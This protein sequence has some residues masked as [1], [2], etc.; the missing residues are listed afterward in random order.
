VTCT[1]RLSEAEEQRQREVFYR[2]V[3]DASSRRSGQYFVLVLARGSRQVLGC[4]KGGPK[5]CLVLGGGN[6]V[7]TSG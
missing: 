6:E 2:L 7:V 1:R 3:A 5:K 4:E